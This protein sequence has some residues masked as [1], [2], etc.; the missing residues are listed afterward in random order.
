MSGFN[1]RRSDPSICYNGRPAASRR[2][3]GGPHIKHFAATLG[4]LLSLSTVLLLSFSSAPLEEESATLP[5][6]ADVGLSSYQQRE[7]TSNG[8]GVTTAIRQNQNMRGFENHSLL[9]AFDAAPVKGW[10]ITR[11]YLHLYL[12][13]GDLHG[14]GL[15]EVLAPWSEPH[16]VNFTTEVGGPSWLFAHTPKDPNHPSDEDWWAWPGSGFC[17][18]AWAQPSARYQ[19]IGP[20]QIERTRVGSPATQSAAPGRDRFL[21]LKLPVEPDL[22]ASLAAGTCNGLVLTDDKGQ[23]AEAY[24]LL[25]PGVPYKDNDAEDIYVFTR[26]VQD[27]TLRPRLEVFGKRNAFPPTSAP[28]GV[29]VI[30]IDA[31]SGTLWMEFAAPVA[32]GGLLAY[33]VSSRPAGKQEWTHLP[34]WALP[35]P[36]AAG[37]KQ[38]MPVWTLPPGPHELA[39]R[40][41]DKSG[42]RGEA[43]IVNITVPPPP[44]AKLATPVI[45]TFSPPPPDSPENTNE[46]T[47]AAVPDL[48]KVDPVSGRVL[49]H[50]EAYLEDTKYLQGQGN[51]VFAGQRVTLTAAANEVAAFQLIVTR[52]VEKLEGL[53]VEVS[54]LAGPAGK[55]IAAR[56]NAQFFRVWYVKSLDKLKEV[57]DPEAGEDRVLRPVAWHGDACLP[58][59]APFDEAFDLPAAD[60][61]VPEQTNQAVWVDFFV[62]KATPAGTYHGRVKVTAG[63]VTATLPLAV[64][65]LPLTLPDEPTWRVEL[66]SYGGLAGMAGLDDKDPKSVEAEY[67][68]YRLAKA[69][70]QMIN[71]LPY[72]QRGTVDAT[73]TPAVG[74]DGATVKVTDWSPWDKRL[75]PLLD[76]SAFTSEKGYVGP[77]AGSPISQLYLPFHENWP[78]PVARHFGDY[79]E[80]GDRL[81]FAEWSKKSRPLEEAYGKDFED[82]FAGMA[83]QFAE[84]FKE[85]GWTRTEFQFLLN[86]KYYYRARFFGNRGR[87]GTSFWLLD[88]P[89]DHDDYAA[90]AFFLSLARRGVESAG[91]PNV[92]F[93]YRADVSTPEMTRGL[94][95]GACDFWMLGWD[96]I[97]AGYVTTARVRQRFIPGERFWQYGGAVSTSGAPVGLVGSFL[98]GWC[99]GSDGILPYWNTM[100]GREWSKADDQAIFY[101]GKN[102][103]RGAKSYP[104]ALPGLRMKIMRRAQQDIEYLQLLS[105]AA[106][107]TRDTVRQALA[108]YADDPAAPSFMFKN[109]TPERAD[110]IRAAVVQ[111]LLGAHH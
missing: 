106:G 89:V 65:I 70:R 44:Q 46:F 61:A 14:V 90:I 50:G 7:S 58:L 84:H 1:L 105:Q 31:G 32:T 91:A 17:S 62:P 45:D 73:R 27:A 68:F 78:L 34:R 39:I 103:A 12:A 35:R 11:A 104:G 64:K 22:V 8:S 23:V 2:L 76:G 19:F 88:E 85:K 67:T 5:V 96:T 3:N 83:R 10:T 41:V 107:W 99:A 109:L 95:N 47:L 26:D 18:I 13:K 60:N 74:G 93:V 6:T 69:H 86:N 20:R 43:T 100:G 49:R 97:P 4:V 108:T 63:G 40:G 53:R 57:T 82:G 101:S 66:N 52:K 87:Q 28:A 33:E 72:S 42:N 75:G 38:V 80:F 48:V 77:G 51:P 79:A 110:A 24:S 55:T 9:M 37:G 94:L 30:R 36:A 71:A 21:H 16:T 15:T 111:T 25:G 92:R 29:K 102:Y 98:A 56:P 59:K 54:D 81:D